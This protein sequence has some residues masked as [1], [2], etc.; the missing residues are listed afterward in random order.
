[1][2]RPTDRSQPGRP[3]PESSSQGDAAVP[4]HVVLER[5]QKTL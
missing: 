1:M 2:S 5:S 4:T 3:D